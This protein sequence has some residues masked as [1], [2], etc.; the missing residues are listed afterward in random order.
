MRFASVVVTALLSLSAC[1]FPKRH[2]ADAGGI[3]TSHPHTVATVPSGYVEATVLDVV[4]SRSGD[5][6]LLIDA[7]GKMVLPIFVGGTEAMTIKLRMDGK[8]YKRPLTHDLLGDVMHDLGGSAVKVQV[9]ELRDDTYIGSAFIEK[10]DGAVVEIDAR[11]SDCIA[12]SLGEHVPIYV[13]KRVFDLAG[14]PKTDFDDD[15]KSSGHKRG[16]PLSL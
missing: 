10:P 12:L 9:D 1:R 8:K 15:A 7:G 13:K 6:V 16:D 11:P 3:A 5:A 4:P 14:V 2:G